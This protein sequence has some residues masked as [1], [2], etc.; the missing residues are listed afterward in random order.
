MQL[1]FCHPQRTAAAQ[2]VKQIRGEKNKDWLV[3]SVQCAA[4]LHN[5]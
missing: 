3:I 2:V 4:S 1:T 5:T